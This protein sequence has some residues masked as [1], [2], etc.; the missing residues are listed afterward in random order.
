M[1]NAGGHGSK[2]IFFCNNTEL[3]SAGS[4][5]LLVNSSKL[6]QLCSSMQSAERG[7]GAF[8]YLP[9][10]SVW[11]MLAECARYRAT[12]RCLARN[13][14]TQ[15]SIQPQSSKKVLL[16]LCF[17]TQASPR[18]IN[19]YRERDRAKCRQKLHCVILPHTVLMIFTI[20]YS[21]IVLNSKHFKPQKTN[22]LTRL[23]RYFWNNEK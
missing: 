3:R 5:L 12:V 20:I 15:S 19:D 23:G 7:D 9:T 6:E 1:T 8:S 11:K 17:C 21:S 14:Y 22:F 18:I 13:T 10:Q 4:M 2:Y 16:L